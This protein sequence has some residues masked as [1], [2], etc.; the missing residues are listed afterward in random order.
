MPMAPGI[1]NHYGGED[2]RSLIAKQLPV[3][4]FQEHMEWR[5]HSRCIA[6]RKSPS[7]RT[8]TYCPELRCRLAFELETIALWRHPLFASKLGVDTHDYP[9]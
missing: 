7:S 5:R 9:A 6:P 4:Q 8:D 2:S 3:T 1:V